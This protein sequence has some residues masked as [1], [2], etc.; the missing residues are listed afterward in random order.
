[1]AESLGG[2]GSPRLAEFKRSPRYR[3]SGD[4]V[5]SDDGLPVLEHGPP[6]L[7]A[8]SGEGDEGSVMAFSLMP[9]AVVQRAAR[10]SGSF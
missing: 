2:I 7:D 5:V 9:F 10:G 6:H 4:L 3:S 8:S 1:M